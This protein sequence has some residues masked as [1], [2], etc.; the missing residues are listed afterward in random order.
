MLDEFNPKR[1]TQPPRKAE[2][3]EIEL[4]D[5]VKSAFSSR[6]IE[7]LYRHQAEGI[8]LAREGKNIVV[9]APTASGK[10]EIYMSAIIDAALKGENSLVVYPT[11]ALSRDQLKRFEQ[12]ALF[13]I[14]AEIYDGDTPQSKREKIRK[15]PPQILIT[16]FDMLHYIL[17][18]NGLFDAYLSRLS[19]LVVDELHTCTGVFGGHVSNIIWRLRRVMERKHKRSLKFICTSATIGNAK[20][21]AQLIFGAEFCE[22]DGEGAPSGPMEHLIVNPE[23]ESYTTTSLRIAEKL[24]KKALVFANSHSVVERLGLMGKRMGLSLAVYRAG[25]DYERRRETEKEFKEGR[26]RILATTSALELG[27]DIGDVDAVILA[28]F[29][30]SITRVRQRIGRAGRKG[31]KAYGIYVAKDNPLDQYYAEKPEEYLNGEPESCFA[32]PN[33]E[34]LVRM[35]LLSASKDA[36]LSES[37]LK[38]F[39]AAAEYLQEHGLLKKLGKFYVPTPQGTQLVR[40]LSIRGIG[41]GIRIVDADTEKQIGEREFPMAI[42]ELFEGAVYLHGGEAYMSEELGLERG[43]AKIRKINQEA[44][45]YTQALSIKEAEVLEEVKTRDILGYPLSFGKV[46]IKTTVH[47][48]AVK[49]TFSGRKLGEHA[50]A[51]PYVYDFNTCG[52]WID[53]DSRAEQVKNFGDG[54][55]GFEHVFIAMIPALTGADA[56]EIGG[57]S[58]PS[59]RMYV[60]DGAPEGNGVTDVVFGRFEKIAAMAK[61]RLASCACDSGC[62]K[63]VLD[64]MC[65]NDNRFLDKGAAR[66]ITSEF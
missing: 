41:R 6:G 18:N 59:G 55:H 53:L 13:G 20:S 10:S 64:P 30:G 47:G 15:S 16:N 8:R 27:M 9:V 36:L 33:N 4:S 40:S 11:K 43:Y 5:A 57:L 63:C 39:E 22:V 32:N 60:Y 31:Q 26:T 35:H 66:E 52:I 12:F 48:F 28:G 25:L 51:E 38:G 44:D 49:E 2:Y 50:F 34:N 54:L 58:Y 45:F 19:L 3:G 23:G 24:E 7:K 61:E 21:F 46:H 62:P 1:F 37:E 17:L 14:R 42:N 56:R 29:P 65:G